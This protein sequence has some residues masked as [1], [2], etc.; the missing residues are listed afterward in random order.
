MNLK[1]YDNGGKTADRYCVV[2]MDWPLWENGYLNR[3]S[4]YQSVS[5]SEDPYWPQGVCMHGGAV[6]GPHLGKRIK[7]D[8]LPDDCKRVVLNDHAPEGWA[9]LKIRG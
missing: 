2:Y 9:L 5:M 8:A 7:W 6:P 3:R 1:I 4:T